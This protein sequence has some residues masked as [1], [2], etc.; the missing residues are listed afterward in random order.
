MATPKLDPQQITP[1]DVAAAMGRA[2][3]EATAWL[4]EVAEAGVAEAQVMLG[5]RLLDGAGAPADPARALQWFHKAAQAGHPM[6]LN[7]V[8]RAYENGWGCAVNLTIAAGFFGRAA[9][10]GSDWG[11]YNYATRLMLGEGVGKDRAM[12]FGWFRKAAAL[13]HAKSINVVGGFHEDG[14]ETPVDLAAARACY[15]Q[16]AA[17]GDFRGKFNLG[18]VLAAEGDVTGALDQFAQAAREATPAF[19]EKVRDFLKDAPIEAY[20]RLAQALAPPPP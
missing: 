4:T 3:A 19:R 7:M 11:M 16:A 15:V 1:A 8:G 20:R 10:A 17:L 6:G 18:R 9:Q 12:A 2:P 13:G 14:W 5:Q